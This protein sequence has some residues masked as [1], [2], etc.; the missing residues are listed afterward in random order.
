MIRGL[1]LIPVEAS[2]ESATAPVVPATP[3]AAVKSIVDASSSSVLDTIDVAKI[4]ERVALLPS[5]FTNRSRQLLTKAIS[6]P[7]HANDL[8][9]VAIADVIKALCIT[10]NVVLSS[11]SALAKMEELGT[12]GLMR[13]IEEALY[14]KQ[15]GEVSYVSIMLRH[16]LTHARGQEQVLEKLVLA[17]AKPATTESATCDRAAIRRI[18]KQKAL[19]AKIETILTVAQDN[20]SL[21]HAGVQSLQLKSAKLSSLLSY[22][23]GEYD[24]DLSDTIAHLVLE[25]TGLPTTGDL[26]V[27][28]R[29]YN[30]A[31]QLLS[32]LWD[33][34]AEDMDMAEIMIP[35]A[36]SRALGLN[37]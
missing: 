23:V 22:T 19:D 24:S 4:H 36:I 14:F 2:A 9:L 13:N 30:A 17:D 1:H 10:H 35:D 34:K 7:R 8:I 32:S 12:N 20:P 27:R 18:S 33:T 37:V 31:T 15:P 3:D 6:D 28:S 21:L 25:E 16:F 5:E 29:V 11:E 26:H